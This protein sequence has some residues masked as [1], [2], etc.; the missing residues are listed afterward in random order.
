MVN[1][2]H[3]VIPALALLLASCNSDHPTPAPDPQK[4]VTD[5]ASRQPE[6]D[7]PEPA[8]TAGS[9]PVSVSLPATPVAPPPVDDA[10]TMMVE[11]PRSDDPRYQPIYQVAIAPGDLEKQRRQITAEVTAYFSM[12]LSQSGT[13]A[14]D[15]EKGTSNESAG[16]SQATYR[17]QVFHPKQNKGPHTQLLLRVWKEASGQIAHEFLP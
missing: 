12:C 9:A 1:P 5:T 15:P 7:K 14:C 10:P 16:F 3:I 13:I 11:C 8:D 2:L 6:V 4:T 17:V